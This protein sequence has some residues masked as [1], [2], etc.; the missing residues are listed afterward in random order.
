MGLAQGAGLDVSIH[1]PD[2]SPLAIQGPKA[3]DLLVEVFGEHVRQIGFFKFD[4]VEF[5]G[6]RQL[7]ARSGF[8]KQGGFEI[9]LE[10]S[11]FGEQLWSRIWQAGEKYNITPGCPNLIER[12][13]GG[14]L[15]Y[16]NEFT[17]EN[18]PL[19]CGLETFCS[20]DGGI[21]CIGLGALQEIA[22]KGVE[23]QMRGVMFDG[24]V[25]P[26]CGIPWPVFVGTQKVGQIT[27]GIWSPRIKHNIG[28]SMIEKSHWDAGQKVMVDCLDGK[29]RTGEIC[30][31]PFPS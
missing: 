31:L 9:Y 10:G 7:L 6:T 22:G 19:E 3:E 4:W 18:N 14:L 23:R 25:A 11:H 2:V 17:R 13:E 24:D 21:D 26:I 16:G 8:S 1:E 27:S 12:I 29:T 15:S 30:Q 5:Q 28:L 20:I